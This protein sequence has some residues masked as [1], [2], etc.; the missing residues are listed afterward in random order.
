MEKQQ[1]FFS[2]VIGSQKPESIVNRSTV[3]PFC[4]TEELTDIIDTNGPIIWL[5]N[6]FPTLQGT[7]Q[8]VLIETDTCDADMRTY[9]PSHM[10]KLIRFSIEKWLQVEKSGEYQ[11]VIL[12]KNHGPLS[13][14]SIHHAHMQIVGMEKLDYHKNMTMAD[15]EGYEIIQNKSID[16]NISKYPIIGITEF[17][18]TLKNYE[19][20][21][22]FSNTLQRL[23]K[24]I[25]GD[26]HK[27]CNS[28]NLFFY[29]F[30][31]RIICKIIPRFVV[32]PLFVGYKIP[33]V[34]MDDR[35]A[36]IKSQLHGL[37]KDE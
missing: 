16:L 6:K 21:D 25:L 30:Q 33:L 5:K 26:F 18:L 11:S 2:S 27:G 7:Y 32:S 13:G 20:I 24:Y 31:D 28:F 35:L 17:N 12:F 3:C 36:L 22:T 10:R 19:D 15:F 14:G 29:H 1:I 8:T 9:S 37:L 23:I 34:L 4:Q